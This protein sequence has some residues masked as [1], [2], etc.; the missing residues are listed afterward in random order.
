MRLHEQREARGGAAVAEERARIAREL[1]DVVAHRVTM[2]VVQAGGA[3]RMLDRDP[4]RAVAARRADRAHGPRGARRDAPPAR[5]AAAGDGARGSR[6]SRARTSSTRSSRGRARPASR[7]TLTSRAT[8]ASCPPGVDLAAY[9]IVQEALT[10]T[11]K[12]GG[13]RA[14]RVPRALRRGRA[15][16]RGR[17]RRAAGPAADGT[18]GPRPGRDARAGAAVRRRARPARGRRRLRGP[19]APAVHGDEA[20]LPRC[21]RDDRAR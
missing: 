7:S 17:R 3:R 14:P 11:I 10:N 13:R 15:A 4:G 1:H 2:M 20:A 5:R 18:G 6:R 19:R 12:H 21:R 9:R 8:P 16:D